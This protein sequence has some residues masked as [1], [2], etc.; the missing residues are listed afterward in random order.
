VTSERKRLVVATSNEGKRLEF[1]HALED[2]GYQLV[3]LPSGVVMPA[4]TGQT[5]QANAR[6]KS[7]S[8]CEQT[9]LPALADDSGLEVDVLQGAPGVYS[10]RYAG[11]GASDAQN[12]RKLLA[13][14]A[15]VEHPRRRARF[16]CALSLVAP[17]GTCIEVQGTCA[18]EI[19]HAPSGSGGF[20][21]DPVFYYPALAGTFAQVSISE[22]NRVSHRAQALHNLYLALKN[23]QQGN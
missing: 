17:D 3:T 21:Y 14:L 4:E 2:L 15:D 20:G 1:A 18:G 13:A 10:A 9:G 6:I 12:I 8:V 11:D 16:V 22:K 5:F 19:A 7:Q 23:M